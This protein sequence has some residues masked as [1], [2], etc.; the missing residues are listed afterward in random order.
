MAKMAKLQHRAKGR[1]PGKA[2]HRGGEAAQK[3]AHIEELEIDSVGA[4]G[5]GLAAGPIYAPLTLAGERVTAEVRGDRAEVT[6]ILRAS[7]QRVAAP[8]PHFG[9]CGGCALQHW[10]AEPYLDWKREQIRVALGWEK[11]ETEILPAFASLPGSRR[12]L[13][14]HARR[15]GAVAVLGF[16]AR[17]S[18]RLARIETCVSRRISSAGSARSMCHAG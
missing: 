6:A 5:D 10:A 17:R 8:C 16:K 7:P 1:R 2:V 14:L 12:R 11:I 9:D 3:P 13:A 15:E 4:Q 18:W